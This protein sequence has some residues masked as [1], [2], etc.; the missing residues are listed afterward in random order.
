MG[1]RTSCT[2]EIGGY[3]SA[4]LLPRLI[5]LANEYA[6]SLDWGGE[7]LTA[8]NIPGDA[9]L[10]L[11]GEELNGGLVDDL[12]AFLLANRLHYRRTSGGCPGAYNPEVVVSYGNGITHAFEA[13][14]DGRVVF[15][16]D[17]IL[18]ATSLTALQALGVFAR[19][20]IPPLTIGDA[21]PAAVPNE[22]QRACAAAYGGGDFAHVTSVGDARTMQD[23][24]F[25]FL[26]IEL[27]ADEGCT[28]RAEAVRRLGSAQ[29]NIQE[30]LDAIHVIEEA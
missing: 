5:E 13:D 8:E 15:S 4:A 12:E 11:Y 30:V 29:T 10:D 17:T 14:E 20:E 16:V 22:F 27:G 23:T 28:D 2:I 21:Q 7:D 18:A 19:R 3:L 26:M 6:L 9:S 1:D 25:T 24:L